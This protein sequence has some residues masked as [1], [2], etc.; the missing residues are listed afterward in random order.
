MAIVQTESCSHSTSKGLRTVIF[1]VNALDLMAVLSRSISIELSIPSSDSFLVLPNKY[2]EKST[3]MSA[4][5]NALSYRQ[6]TPLQ[7]SNHPWP[8]TTSE[9][10][11]IYCVFVLKDLYLMIMSIQPN[12]SILYY[13]SIIHIKR[14]MDQI[15]SPGSDLSVFRYCVR[16]YGDENKTKC[17]ILPSIYTTTRFQYPINPSTWTTGIL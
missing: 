10:E 2:Q 17:L 7:G 8:S 15:I 13:S 5:R 16:Q 9:G 11:I 6:Y 14:R 1:Q 4:L 12:P 3:G